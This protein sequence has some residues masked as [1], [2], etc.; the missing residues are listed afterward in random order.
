MLAKIISEHPGGVEASWTVTWNVVQNAF[1]EEA[2]DRSSY[3]QSVDVI[4]EP[5]S[6]RDNIQSS[7]KLQHSND[8]RLFLELEERGNKSRSEI[9]S[10]NLG[11]SEALG[12]LLETL[13]ATLLPEAAT[14]SMSKAFKLVAPTGNGNIIRSN[15]LSK[16]L[17]DLEYI[18]NTTDF[19]QPLQHFVNDQKW[20]ASTDLSA[21][22]RG[23]IGGVR[24]CDSSVWQG[25]EEAFRVLEDELHNRLCM[26]LVL[27]DLKRQTILYVEG[28]DS[29]PYRGACSAQMYEAAHSLG[30]DIVLLADKD[31]ELRQP[32]YRNWYKD[33]IPVDTGYDAGFS[34][35]IVNAVRQY[36]GPIDAMLSVF[37]SLHVLVSKAAEELGFPH[38]PTSAYEIATSKYRLSE[39]EGR[40]SFI[41]S[42]ADQAMGIA[43][44]ENV[45]WPIIIKPCRG[46]GS[47]LVFKVDNAQQLE[48]A[49]PSMNT[50]R[51]GTEFVME[52]Y[53]DGPE[54]DINFVMYEGEIIFWGMLKTGI[55]FV[56]LLKVSGE[57]T[58]YRNC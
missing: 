50:E 58:C 49:A 40:N 55:T 48:A 43:R 32:E 51:H 21:C 6:P 41:A 39:F 1:Q 27:P 44:T 45:P 12:F 30:I 20:K 56:I 10:E 15:I 13:D 22:F 47:E 26:P 3:F 19:S 38:E 9:Q 16:R 24:L 28:G 29:L 4:I 46:W 31:H 37:E 35:R 14:G 18:E 17:Q 8:V 5:T 34:S 11:S 42:S 7:F 52:H 53:C 54:V 25:I 57:L 33:F 36:E 2:L 23:A